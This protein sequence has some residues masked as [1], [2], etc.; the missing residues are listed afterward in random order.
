[1]DTDVL[2][3]R[4]LL[5]KLKTDDE[6]MSNWTPHE[7][8]RFLY[9]TWPPN[10][11]PSKVSQPL[12]EIR[13]YGPEF[14]S[15]QNVQAEFVSFELGRVEVPLR[16]ECQTQVSVQIDFEVQNRANKRIGDQGEEVVY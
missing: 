16:P 8:M 9:S 1:M 12:T 5:R 14:P 11:K 7:Y 6:V 3:K 13:Q 2:E 10:P 4:Q 15:A